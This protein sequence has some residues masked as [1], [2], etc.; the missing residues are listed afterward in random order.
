MVDGDDDWKAASPALPDPLTFTVTL[1]ATDPEGLSASVS[2]DFITD[3][4]SYPELVSA[5][6]SRQ[7]V[8]LTF[9]LEVQGSLVPSSFT[10]NVVNEDGSAGTIA[11]SSVV[12]NGRAVTLALASAL[13]R[14]QTVTLDYAHDDATPL[15]R[16]AEGGD[17]LPSFTGQAVEVSIPDLPG[18]PQNLDLSSTPGS[19]DISATWDTL[20]GATSYK[21]R[22]RQADGEFEA[23]NEATV[24]E[25]TATVTVAGYGGW[26][27]QVEGCNDAGCG[28]AVAQ[29]VGI[30][31][32]SPANFAVS[33][34]PD[35]LDLSATWDALDGA[36]SYKLRWRPAD[37]E[38]AA[39]NEATVT[40][41]TATVTVSGQGRWA[42]GLQG[43]ND[44]GCGPEVEASA[45]V[46]SL[47]FD[48][49]PSLDSAGNPRPHT[50]DAN[51]SP[52]PNATGYGL[53]WR[54]MDQG[55]SPSQEQSDGGS[56]RKSDIPGPSGSGG[57]S[58]ASGPQGE[59]RLDIPGDQ[60]SAEFTVDRDGTFEVE[61]EVILPQSDEPIGMANTH[62]TADARVEGSEAFLNARRW[63]IADS[64]FQLSGCQTRRITG[65]EVAFVSGHVEVAWDDPRL[66]AITEY[67]Y[68]FQRDGSFIFPA[69][70][71]ADW[72]AIPGSGA[73]TTSFTMGVAQSP[74]SYNTTDLALNRA[75][76]LWVRA[77][78]GGRAYCFE[79]LWVIN[80]F[81]VEVP[82]ITGLEAYQTRG[83]G[84]RQLS[85][86]WDDPQVSGLTYDYWYNGLT[87][88]WTGRGQGTHWL[89]VS[90]SPPVS[91]GGGKLTSTLSGIPC[92]HYYYNVRIRAKQ[93]G[94][95]GPIT[96]EWYVDLA[97]NW[98]GDPDRNDVF[99][100]ERYAEC[101]FGLA[102]DDELHGNGGD[103]WLEG[104][105]GDDEL[106]GGPGNDRLDGGPGGDTLNGGEG[107]DTADYAGSNARVV[108][109]LNTN[110]ASGG[111]AQGDRLTSIEN[112]TGSAHDDNL[113]G[114]AGNNVLRGGPGGDELDG[115]EGID[116]AG[117][118]R[119]RPG[120][121]RHT[122]VP[123]TGRAPTCEAA[124]PKATHITRFENI[125]GSAHSDDFPHRQRRG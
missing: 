115:G 2:G 26:V 92:D 96:E 72:H 82:L 24:T 91:A 20:D 5:T 121:D 52:V 18:P 25:T 12:V 73:G 34:T 23:G 87:P 11:V 15:K 81:D 100:G 54:L 63:P 117:L 113:R 56:S 36:T 13:E 86:F 42:V 1:T 124:T 59:N 50:F 61:L 120:R 106:Y 111:H 85:L 55:N 83:D 74:P 38:F 103:D 69:R 67:Q 16:A 68:R 98:F 89:P 4:V 110:A 57:P 28:P 94:S 105:P 78:A 64:T 47:S 97:S 41:T 40:E 9:D 125:T 70:R 45:E 112:L 108:V 58:A 7:A 123:L 95:L 10:V 109:N 107:I 32:G 33:A 88:D 76:F 90:G 77:L 48:V 75:N 66:S 43:C 39:G 19:L 8:E 3:W 84:P 62:L 30:V 27:V 80:P 71:E 37:G 119:L 29:S 93:G 44:A 116:W 51:W 118:H 22:W 6:A 102:G 31:P 49:S 46:S 122:A 35:S 99:H 21:L 101:V 14:G 53:R 17:S 79:Y 114:D 60:T 65:A 104:G